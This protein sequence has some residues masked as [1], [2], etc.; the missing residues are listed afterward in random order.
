V[1]HFGQ[2]GGREHDGTLFVA[3]N[4]V[5]TPFLAPVVELST[6]KAKARLV[7][8]FIGDGGHRQAQQTVAAARDGARLQEVTGVHKQFS[9]DFTAHARRLGLGRS[10]RFDRLNA[11]AFAAPALGDYRPTVRGGCRGRMARSVPGRNKPAMTARDVERGIARP[12]E[13]AFSHRRGRVAAAR[14]PGEWP[15]TGSA[16]H[17]ACG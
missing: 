14:E 4:T 17:R 5:V 9:G 8:N 16:G 12:A 11:E 3:F 10:N 6:A 15:A 1:I 7:G 13:P 2:D